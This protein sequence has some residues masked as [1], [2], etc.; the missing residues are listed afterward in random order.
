MLLTFCPFFLEY[1]TDIPFTINRTLIGPFFFFIFSSNFYFFSPRFLLLAFFSHCLRY[2]AVAFHSSKLFSIRWFFFSFL[3]KNCSLFHRIESKSLE[4]LHWCWYIV[5]LKA[6][7]N[8]SKREKM[9]FA[10]TTL[11]FTVLDFRKI[12]KKR[13]SCRWLFTRF[14][15]NFVDV[16]T[17]LFFCHWSTLLLSQN[18]LWFSV[19]PI[20]FLILFFLRLT[21]N[22]TNR[23]Q[24]FEDERKNVSSV[25]LLVIETAIVAQ[26]EN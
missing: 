14:K 8:Q 2:G 15:R 5:D 20:F 11:T 18:Q 13:S 9:W 3:L 25:S 19:F 16:R 21:Y 1:S 23:R 4:N 22:F 12:K 7:N 6:T 26:I 10:R 17:L 24:T